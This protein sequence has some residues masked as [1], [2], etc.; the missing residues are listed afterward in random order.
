MSLFQKQIASYVFTFVVYVLLLPWQTALLLMGGIAFHEM[1]HLYA[2]KKMGYESK[3]FFLFP[4]LGGLAL[5]AGETKKYSHKAFIVIM[6]PIAGGFLALV[7][8][9]LYLATGSYFLGEAALWM[10][11]LNL[12]NLAPLSFLDGGQILE[13]VVYSLHPTLGLIVMTISTIVAVPVLWF[14]NPMIA[15]VVAV[16][17]GLSIYSDYKRWQLTKLGYGDAFSPRPQ[18]MNWKQLT[19][20]ITS[21]VFVAAGLYILMFVLEKDFLDMSSLFKR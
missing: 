15:G 17:G 20:T 13:S 8:Y 18:A 10:A 3:G 2:G 6:G 4:F 14:F 7:T 5:S 1:G 9:L 11:F 19:L 12:F 16:V 21:T